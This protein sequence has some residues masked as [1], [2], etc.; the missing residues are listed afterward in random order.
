MKFS[1]LLQ[2]MLDGNELSPLEKREM[3]E[4]AKRQE[5][6]TALLN[7]I[8]RP[9]TKIIVA[10]GLV[11]N[12][13]EINRALIQNAEITDA[14]IDNATITNVDI[15][16]AEIVSATAGAGDVEIDST[17]IW[18]KNAASAQGSS[19]FGIE[20]STGQRNKIYMI[21]DAGNFLWLI[22]AVA[23]AGIRLS[24]VNTGLESRELVFRE[25]SV[26]NNRMQLHLEEGAQG[27]KVTVGQY[28]GL[29]AKGA[30]GGWSS[31]QLDGSSN[32]TPTADAFSGN[33]YIRNSKLVF[34]WMD[35]ATTRYKYL[36]LTGTGVTWVHTTTPP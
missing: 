17:G 10:D 28:M 34:Q 33:V 19:A 14:T 9:G 16:N 21:A 12:D 24:I 1:E 20:T 36:D 31:L 22:N 5:Q 4:E 6:T 23:G 35:G 8:L 2:K 29:H 27:G 26:T 15:D 18:M 32:N 11:S 7:S 25:D 3:V 13:A 30:S